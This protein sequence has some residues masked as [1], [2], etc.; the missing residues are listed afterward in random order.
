MKRSA[1]ISLSVAAILFCGSLLV[2]MRVRRPA[3]NLN[4]HDGQGQAVSQSPRSGIWSAPSPT[5]MP[6]VTGTGNASA[7]SGSETRTTGAAAIRRNAEMEAMGKRCSDADVNELVRILESDAEGEIIASWG[8]QHLG[9]AWARM[10][11][12]QVVEAEKALDRSLLRSTPQHLPAR[13]S[14]LALARSNSAYARAAV[15]RTVRL[16]IQDD[17][18]PDLDNYIRVIGMLKLEQYESRLRRLSASANMFV[19]GPAKEALRAW[20]DLSVRGP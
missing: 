16:A 4:N 2:I 5:P 8:A 13:E 17:N 10:S 14:L 12:A 6:R 19:A 20:Q 9:L 15:E 1:S 11:P 7:G 18:N 3:S